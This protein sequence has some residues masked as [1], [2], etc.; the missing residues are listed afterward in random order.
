MYNSFCFDYGILSRLFPLKRTTEKGK[1]QHNF[2]LT[3]LYFLQEVVSQEVFCKKVA[4][5]KF[6]KFTKS[7]W[8]VT[9]EL[10]T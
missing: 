7:M 9:C 10:Q 2:P 1:G 4:L 6:A 8:T 3:L 5:K